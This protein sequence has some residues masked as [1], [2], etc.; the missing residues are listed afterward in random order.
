VERYRA[1]AA[2]KIVAERNFGGAM[3]E[4]VIK[5]AD[6]NAPV[7]LVTASR[8]KS[9]RAEPVAALYE[10][11]RV[12]HAAGLE[13]LEDQMCQMTLTGFVGE[14][15]PDRVDALVWAMTELMAGSSFTLANV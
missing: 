14:G 11:G 9:I 12:T 1:H 2:D 13:A 10:Q 15:S 8:G 7:K 6:R 4:S 3:V 5:T